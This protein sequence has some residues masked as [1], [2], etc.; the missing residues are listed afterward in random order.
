M[1]KTINPEDLPEGVLK[2]YI[3]NIQAIYNYRSISYR[4][5]QKEL[6]GLYGIDVDI[7]R[8]EENCGAEEQA[9]DLA[10]QF[11]NLGIIC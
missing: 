4:K 6:K 10:Q 9:A 2:E 7:D 1:S 5:I 11:K 8:I 3:S